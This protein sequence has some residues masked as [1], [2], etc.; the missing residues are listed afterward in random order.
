MDAL[1]NAVAHAAE[2]GGGLHR[3]WNV[4]SEAVVSLSP[5]SGHPFDGLTVTHWTA[6]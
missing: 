1:T 6:D 4:G 2:H 5:G 3:V